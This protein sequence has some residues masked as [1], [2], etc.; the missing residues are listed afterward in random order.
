RRQRLRLS[1]VLVPTL[2]KPSEVDRRF[3]AWLF[4]RDHEVALFAEI[5][6]ADVLRHVTGI[7][8]PFDPI[9]FTAAFG[10]HCAQAQSLKNSAEYL[11]VGLGLPQ[12][13]DAL[14]LQ[15]NNA[16]IHTVEPMLKVAAT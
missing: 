11:V 7:K 16:V 1:D 3:K 9:K 4:W 15:G 14:V 2:S 12:G 6:P 10:E 5:L 8:H 13:L